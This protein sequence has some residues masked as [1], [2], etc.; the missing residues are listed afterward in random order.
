MLRNLFKSENEKAS[1]EVSGDKKGDSGKGLRKTSLL[2][3][4]IFSG[5]WSFAGVVFPARAQEYCVLREK[6]VSAGDWRT[7]ESY[8]NNTGTAFFIQPT[9]AEIKVRYGKFLGKDRQK[10]TLDGYNY[11]KLSVG[12]GSLFYARIQIKVPSST[13]VTYL[14]CS[15]TVAQSLPPIRFN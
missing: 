12:S 10:Q 8:W 1:I 14:A 13:Y 4:L 6:A 5:T 7:L 3:A 2:L 9:G 15:G 11:K